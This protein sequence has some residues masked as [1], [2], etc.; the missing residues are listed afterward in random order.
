MSD[1]L[2]DALARTA[3][4]APLFVGRDVPAAQALAATHD[5]HLRLCGPDDWLTL[6]LQTDR[7]TAFVVDG[8]V[9]RAQAG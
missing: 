7:V 9:T 5:L 6:D 3:A 4:L 2:D 1:P 8:V